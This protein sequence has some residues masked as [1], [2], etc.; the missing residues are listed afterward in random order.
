[1][2]GP[3]HLGIIAFTLTALVTFYYYYLHLYGQD[4]ELQ[5]QTPGGH[6]MM[7]SPEHGMMHHSSPIRPDPSRQG[8]RVYVGNLSWN[9]DKEQL[10]QHMSEVGDVLYAEVLIEPSGRSKGCGIVEYANAS[11]AAL[12]MER[13]H[14]T[15]LNGRA[16]FVREDRE[17]GFSMQP[18][19]HH[20]VN[21]HM[22]HHP[23]MMAG[24]MMGM[25]PHPHVPPPHPHM[26]M[27]P[28]RGP[29][30]AMPPSPRGAIGTRVF[31]VSS[32]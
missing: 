32:L 19:P 3:C 17:V 7:G 5:T 13:M 10:R 12:A 22:G 6:H 24:G 30:G 15:T 9:V 4:R 20:H 25:P 1:M 2:D 28:P 29:F 23:H 11:Q 27:G 31:V 26:M 16:I 14:N 8:Q 18:M 21:G